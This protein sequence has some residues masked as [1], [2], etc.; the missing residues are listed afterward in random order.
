M[1]AVLFILGYYG[2]AVGGGAEPVQGKLPAPTS[3]PIILAEFTFDVDKS[4][5]V[6][7]EP[8]P[9]T[10][11]TKRYPHIN[12]HVKLTYD[13]QVRLMKFWTNLGEKG[14]KICEEELKTI[15]EKY[16]WH[17]QRYGVE[18]LFYLSGTP[19]I[20]GLSLTK[21]DSCDDPEKVTISGSAFIRVVPQ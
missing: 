15:I 1:L 7:E 3:G 6:T 21:K 13:G 10:G 12:V 5:C 20:D 16:Q 17:P 11:G 18:K 9:K 8:E 19:V 2:N 4:R 14:E